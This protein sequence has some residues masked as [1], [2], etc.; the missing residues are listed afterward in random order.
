MRIDEAGRRWGNL[1]AVAILVL[2]AVP[3]LLRADGIDVGSFTK[4]TSAAPVSQ[5][6]PH[7]L[8]ETP[9]LVILF[10]SG[11]TDSTPSGDAYFGFGASDGSSEYAIAI[12]SDNGVGTSNTSRRI[13]T[14]AISIVSWGESTVAEADLTAW[15]ADDFTL[16][17]TTNDST[18][19]IVHYIAIG[20][21][22]ISASVDNW[23]M[24]TS[25]GNQSVTGVGFQPDVVIHALMGIHTNSP[26]S[27]T[28][29][30]E[31]GL[32]VMDA[33]G[34]QWCIAVDAWDG[35]DTTRCARIQRS[36][37]C[38]LSVTP[39]AALGVSAQFVSM[40][41]NGF[42]VDFVD[43]FNAAQ[44]FSISIAGVNA[45]AGTFDK[46]TSGS[47]QEVNGVLFQPDFLLLA[48]WQRTSSSSGQDHAR[49]GIGVSDGTDEGCAGVQ[50]EDNSGTADCDRFDRTD[51]VFAVLD[52]DSQ[53]PSALA[54]LSSFDAD[55]FTLNWSTN[56][57]TATQLCYLA[58]VP[59]AAIEA[60]VGDLQAE[61]GPG[62]TDV[63]WRAETELDNLGFHVLR[64]VP[65]GA[66]ARI[67][68]LIAGSA[69][70][71]PAGTALL[72]AQRYSF[73]D[74]AGSPGD[75]YW[76]EDIDLEGTTTL[77]G[78][79][80]AVAG[81]GGASGATPA[82]GVWAMAAAAPPACT[83]AAPRHADAVSPID[84]AVAA[85]LAARPALVIGVD[86]EGWVRVTH[87][88]WTAAGLPTPAPADRLQLFHRGVEHAIEVAGGADG[89]FGPG[90]AVAFL[91]LGVD[92][93][94][95]ATACY[96][97]TVGGVPGKR[98]VRPPLA[99]VSGPIPDAFP[100]TVLAAEEI[101]YFAALRNGDADNFFG[102]LVSSAPVTR[103][104]CLPHRATASPDP[105][106]LEVVLQGI[107]AG[108]RQVSV[109][110]DGIPLG[111]VT[112]A[113]MER[114][115]AAFALPAS[116]F[117]A[118]IDV[119]VATG[120]PGE[121]AFIDGISAT[122]PREY[123]AGGEFLR[124]TAPASTPIVV[125][126]A[127]PGTRIL[128]VT[129]PAAVTAPVVVAQPLPGGTEVSLAFSL[130]GAGSR[131][132]ASVP[133]GSEIAPASLRANSP[134]AWLS[135]RAGAEFVIVV[136]EAWTA[137]V[138]PLARQRRSEGLSTLVVAAEDIFDELAG[139]MADPEAIRR[140]A[141]HAS[142]R[143]QVPPRY[144][145]LVG[146][147]TV[148]PRGRLPGTLPT[149]L[150]VRLI[151]SARLETASDAVLGD[152]DGDGTIDVAVGRLPFSTA[153][154]V[155]RYVARKAIP[156]AIVPAA[157]GGGRVLVVNDDDDVHPFG[158]AADR[159]R[160]LVPPA[161][162]RRVDRN[163][164][165]VAVARAMIEGE[166]VAGPR[167]VA[168]FGHG[169]TGSWG[170][171]DLL[172]TARVGIIGHATIHPVVVGS[173]CLNGYF[174]HRTAETLAETWV[175]SDLGALAVISSTTLANPHAQ[176][177][178]ALAILAELQAAAAVRIG[179]A[180]LAAQGAA[181]ADTVRTTI[182]LGDPT[183]IHRR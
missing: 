7:S 50:D 103:T 92:I 6:V 38:I 22:G 169:G 173:S 75:R 168:Y 77:H 25:T 109:A 176:T 68:P 36:D 90:D 54:D 98:I 105:I 34:D 114:C 175:G 20:G 134:S 117:G 71:A 37:R 112:F 61:S 60:G 21:T 160:L 121:F 18:A 72:S 69:F 39:D 140:F 81:A 45:E 182:L 165:S 172:T 129:D 111:D 3:S 167:L 100:H 73:I 145:L 154:E 57:A 126:P 91:G 131:T 9:D 65:G 78:P 4:S 161:A 28:Q 102:E 42:T 108:E 40:D 96:W 74:P 19:M 151:D 118:S 124:G 113:G 132:W 70:I 171:E 143:W 32:G 80:I 93:P 2:A 123:A 47:S 82:V 146:D 170:A 88:D 41:S 76:V 27:S 66:P 99:A 48:S 106:E 155:A 89:W 67:S 97:L 1:F 122:Y 144:L 158:T 53:S 26:S 159:V 49:I 5:V 17:W 44:V 137:A 125:S 79:V 31:F 120:G 24:P 30:A 58:L 13:A 14:K 11:E 29:N 51:K 16:N 33:T 148:D 95:T 130:P 110:V 59:F 127:P 157:P 179:D 83:P 135:H 153:A 128:D 147:A 85:W 178:L 139:G 177:E 163:R 62:G 156:S 46:I 119:T 141:I 23:T 52:S 35:E 86:R 55:G 12:A 115:V 63:S 104:L 8:G 136:P 94:S 116:G 15:D 84:P 133:P 101:S 149:S 180:L 43:I 10:T 164:T 183:A 64:G 142:Q 152:L 166:L 174:H 181:D 87:D 150:P 138:E 107:G 162:L 56:S